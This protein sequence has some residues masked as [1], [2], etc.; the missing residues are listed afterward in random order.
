[1]LSSR[2][3]SEARSSFGFHLIPLYGFWMIGKYSNYPNIM[4]KRYTM[5]ET[6]QTTIKK[7]KR[8]VPPKNFLCIPFTIVNIIKSAIM[9]RIIKLIAEYRL[10]TVLNP[11]TLAITCKTINTTTNVK[12]STLNFFYS[13]LISLTMYVLESNPDPIQLKNLLPSENKLQIRT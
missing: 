11:Y 6:L 8:M 10:L 2:T 3:I 7:H 1:M 9:M 5:L 13:L 12:A 4:I